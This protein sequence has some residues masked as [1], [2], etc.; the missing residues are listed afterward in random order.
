MW[1]VPD[2]LSSII[3]AYMI[4]SGAG[5]SA[6]AGISDF[7]SPEGLF[8]TMKEQY[9]LAPFRNIEDLFDVA[10]LHSRGSSAFFCKMIGELVD[11]SHSASP[12]AFHKLLRHLDEAGQ[13]LRIYTQNIDCLKSKSNISFG[14]PEHPAVTRS[15]SHKKRKTSSPSWHIPSCI[16]LHGRIDS[17]YCLLCNQTYPAHPYISTFLDGTLPVCD[18][19][20]QVEMLRPWS[21]KRSRGIGKLRPSIVLYN[22]THPFGDVIGEMV[23]HDLDHVQARLRLDGNV[24]L[25]VVGTSLKISGVKS[26]VCK[27][28][29]ILHSARGDQDGSDDDTSAICTIYVNRKFPTASREWE[30]V[31]DAWVYGHPCEI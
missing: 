8:Q 15:I 5:I 27:F 29:K 19:C 23:S 14:L 26:M 31:F 3:S 28:A 10:A 18:Q 4:R 16:P 24:V 25:L 11:K 17:V 30:G 12:T 6:E 7:R 22:E 13:I 9:P 21:N 20:S 1:S 2:I